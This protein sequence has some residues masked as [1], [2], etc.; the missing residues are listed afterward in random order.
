MMLNTA[1]DV[2]KFEQ[3]R[4]RSAFQVMG[5]CVCIAKAAAE[6]LKLNM[7]LILVT[8]CRN[9]LTRLRSTAVNSIF[10]F[11]D[12]INFHKI[13]ASAI[14]I[15][16]VV[17]ILA[18]VTCGFP[19][20]ITCPKSKFMTTMGL[21]FNYKQPTYPS[22]LGSAPGVTGILMILI[23]TFSFTLATHSFISVAKV[24]S[25]LHHLAGF[26]AFWYARHLLA[27]VYGLLVVHSY[28]IFFT[29]KWYKKTACYAFSSGNG[30][31][32]SRQ[33][34]LNTCEK[35][36]PG[37]KYKSGMYLFI[38]YPDVSPFEW[39]PFSI[40]SAPGN[41]YWSVHIRSLGDWTTALR[42]LFGKACEAQVKSKK[43]NLVRPET[44]EMQ[45]EDEPD[46]ENKGNGPGR[47]YFYWVTRKQ[48]SFEWFKG[49]MD[50]VAVS[51]HNNVIEMHN[52]L[53]SVY[54][55]GDVRS[56]LMAMVQ[57]LQYAKSDLDIVS[58]SRDTL[59]KAK[60]EESVF[61]CGSVKLTQLN[62]SQEFSNDTTTR[63]DFH[64][65][66]L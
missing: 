3:Y 58:G 52:Y 60:L 11:D 21:N 61:Y 14:A 17:H 44:T 16:T 31:H 45:N 7:A 49:V 53:T 48:G 2:W 13:I 39:H 27:L 12:S 25:P 24:P 55:E 37:F 42:N 22:L 19:R 33:C 63:F 23:M 28:F 57:S 8:V 15:G 51:D 9:M 43:A 4:R 5:Y 34:P 47:A 59:C 54:E 50:E 62:L 18:H 10:P 40:T 1:L 30:N 20:I 66:N 65:E 35:A 36:P 41:G 38:K 29:K 46:S 6:T 56:T 32:I 26:I 64:K